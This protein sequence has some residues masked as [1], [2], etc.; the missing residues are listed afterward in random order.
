MHRSD[1]DPKILAE[2]RSACAQ[3]IEWSKQSNTT[4]LQTLKTQPSK[5]PLKMP[6]HQ[7]LSSAASILAKEPI[8]GGCKRAADSLSITFPPSKKPR[9]H[10]ETK[11]EI[12]QQPGQT[13]K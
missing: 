6:A 9:I 11:T 5:L 3:V 8:Q 2:L 13:F 4:I 7:P 12:N 1:I 10:Q